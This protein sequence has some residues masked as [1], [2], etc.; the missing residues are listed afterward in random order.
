VTEKLQSLYFDAVHG[1]GDQYADWL[2][3]V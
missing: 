1:R 3:Y 2:T